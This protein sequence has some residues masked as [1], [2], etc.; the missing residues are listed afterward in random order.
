[1]FFVPV[2]VVE[3]RNETSLQGAQAIP[4]FVALYIKQRGE[5]PSE[6]AIRICRTD[7][8]SYWDAQSAMWKGFG[9]QYDQRHH[10]MQ[11][12]QPQVE[13]EVA[14]PP[15]LPSVQV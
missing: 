15:V 4:F 6:K 14:P 9:Q 1:M 2:A 7:D 8:D 11:H 13:K 5:L 10:D 3:I 12:L